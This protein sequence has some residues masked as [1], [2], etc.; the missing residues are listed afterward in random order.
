[1]NKGEFYNMSEQLMEFINRIPL[2]RTIYFR[3]GGALFALLLLC[4]SFIVNR[5]KRYLIP[6]LPVV[7][8]TALLMLSIPGPA[9]RYIMIFMPYA[10]FFYLFALYCPDR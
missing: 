6:L 3:G 8:Y 2:L 10:V 4:A 9:V 5:E 1:M 7:I